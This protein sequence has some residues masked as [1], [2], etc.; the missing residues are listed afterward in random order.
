MNIDGNTKV[1]SKRLRPN[2]RSRRIAITSRG[3]MSR[4]MSRS[5]GMMRG[6]VSTAYRA[7]LTWRP[8]EWLELKMSMRSL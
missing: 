4:S 6:R 8:W 7:E 3:M 2:P 1:E 5:K